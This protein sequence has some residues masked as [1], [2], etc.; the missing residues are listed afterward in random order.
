MSKWSDWNERMAESPVV[1]VVSLIVSIIAFV[2]VVI[3]VSR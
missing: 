2:V 1:Y 3:A